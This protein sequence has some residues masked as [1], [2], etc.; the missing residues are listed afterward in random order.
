MTERRLL[1][2][3]SDISPRDAIYFPPN[4]VELIE[5]DMTGAPSIDTIDIVAPPDTGPADRLGMIAVATTRA[6]AGSVDQTRRG[7]ACVA[8][9]AC[10]RERRLRARDL[11]HRNRPGPHSGPPAGGPGT[12]TCHNSKR[13]VSIRIAGANGLAVNCFRCTERHV[14]FTGPKRFSGPKGKRAGFDIESL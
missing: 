13:P 6:R 1:A 9:R 14:A 5:W 4:G 10:V 7:G 8:S 12:V 3:L 2:S 11:H